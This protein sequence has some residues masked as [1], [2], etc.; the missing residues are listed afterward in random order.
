MDRVGSRG[1]YRTFADGTIGRDG[2]FRVSYR[3]RDPSSRGR[4]NATAETE[5]YIA[6]PG[7]ALAYKIGQLKIVE[8]RER[9]KQ[10]LGERF[11]LSRFH[12]FILAGGDM[13]L[14]LLERRV[15]DWV[16]TQKAGG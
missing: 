1:R 7:Q 6:I 9:A 4:T 10:Q 12:D 8:L 16:A 13:P 3:F 2:R 11:V 15:D 14:M 5:R